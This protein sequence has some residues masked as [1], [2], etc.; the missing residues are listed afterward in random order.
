MTLPSTDERR[1][2]AVAQ[3]DPRADGAFVYAVKSTGIYCRPT[4]A[5]RL[6][7]RR[8]VT[9]FPGPVQAKASGFRPCRRCSPDAISARAEAIALVVAACTHIERASAPPSLTELAETVGMS[10]S[11]F[12]RLFK[13]M[14]GITP[15]AYAA[16]HRTRR[17][18]EALARG[19]SVTRA[20]YEA[21]F[22]A[23]S[24]LYEGSAERLGMTPH[25]YKTGAKGLDI[26]YAV[27]ASSLGP[28]LVAATD[29]GICA[30]TFGEHMEGLFNDLRSRFPLARLLE[31]DASFAATVRR[32]VSLIETP[33]A[34]HDLPLD[35]Q[36]TAFQQ[37]VWQALRRIPP[38]TTASYGDVARSL[39][40]PTAA[41][42]VAGACARNPLAVAIPCHRV[43]RQDGGLG[44]YRWGMERKRTLLDRENEQGPVASDAPQSTASP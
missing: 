8:N 16:E 39:G 35:I 14:V 38:G 33:V 34:G 13:K 1:W 3:R 36:G 32:V 9:Y 23:S 42:A 28:V 7:N 43:V 24:R 17:L 6:P 26:N 12:H 2:Q 19:W 41:R 10:R 11:R 25:R 37:R 18:K 31:A 15:R 5:S 20:L 22:N 21:G 30:I 44:G 4:C 40:R 29:L 27:T